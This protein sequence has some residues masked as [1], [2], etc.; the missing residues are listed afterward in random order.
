MSLFIE[1]I[2]LF[3]GELRN[4]EFHQA[5]FERS[6]R[7]VLGL[8]NHPRLA[9]AIQLPE[10]LEKS[11]LKCRI[12]YGTVID[13]IE[14]EPPASREIHSLKLVYSDS[15]DYRYKYAHR[16]NLLE[17][18]EQRG[19]CDDILVVKNRCITDS[20]Y[21]NVVFWD[22]REWITPDTPLL[23]GTMRAFLLSRALIR[24]ER[25]G[26]ENLHRFQSFKLINAMH[27]L[28]QAPE[29]PIG[30]IHQ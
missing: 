30:S 29:I 15:I 26:P 14:Y 3:H 17:L 12:S 10:G 22:G 4:L 28:D 2:Q 21:A 11:Q 6:R 5:R 25:I 8:K 16:S 23:Q 7:D 13:L 18:L 27:A 19:A 1:T 9:D 20:F 24:E